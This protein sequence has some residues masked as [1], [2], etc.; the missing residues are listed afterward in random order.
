MAKLYYTLTIFKR[1]GS[2]PKH[3]TELI[4][5]VTKQFALMLNKDQISINNIMTRELAHTLAVC[6]SLPFLLSAILKGGVLC[7]GLVCGKFV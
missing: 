7:V 6:I 2:F 4:I 3:F 1:E 5:K